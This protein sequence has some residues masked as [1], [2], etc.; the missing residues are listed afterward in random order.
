MT[1]VDRYRFGS[2]DTDT[3]FVLMASLISYTSLT[4]AVF[5]CSVQQLL[6]KRNNVFAD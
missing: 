4:D 3:A 5:K 1:E 2:A 6:M